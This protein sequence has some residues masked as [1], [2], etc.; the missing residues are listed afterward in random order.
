M[1]NDSMQ[2]H[3]RG[4][5]QLKLIGFLLAVALMILGWGFNNWSNAVDKGMTQ[6]MDKLNR[7]EVRG[8]QRDEQM[9]KLAQEVRV[10]NERQIMMRQQM[11]RAFQEG[12]HR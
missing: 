1:T 3:G 9:N 8:E 12:A 11:D 10:L 2:D 7:M 6:V 4:E 5:V